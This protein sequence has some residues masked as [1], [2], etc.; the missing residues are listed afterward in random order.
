MKN[1]EAKTHETKH[2]RIMIVMIQNLENR[3]E[4]MQQSS[5]KDIEELKNKHTETTPLLKLK[6]L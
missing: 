4:K 1:C 5:N 6:I 3:M 2:F